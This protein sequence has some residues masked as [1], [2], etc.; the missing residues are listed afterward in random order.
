MGIPADYKDSNYVGKVP[1]SPMVTM[2][3]LIKEE[4]ALQEYVGGD[5][6]RLGWVPIKLTHAS[7]N[8]CIS[9][10]SDATGYACISRC[11]MHTLTTNRPK[12]EVQS[13]VDVAVCALPGELQQAPLI[14]V[15]GHAWSPGVY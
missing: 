2:L 10:H 7:G 5:G 4:L 11:S 13:V 12:T 9:G 15:S 3:P 6:K 8:A 14:M 1:V